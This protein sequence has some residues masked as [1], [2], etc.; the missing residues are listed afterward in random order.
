MEEQRSRAAACSQA[1]LVTAG[2][3]LNHRS[4]RVGRFAFRRVRTMLVVPK[5]HQELLPKSSNTSASRTENMD[6]VTCADRGVD[7][8]S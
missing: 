7:C 5:Q 3:G 8:N 6:H 1:L 2:D 4:T